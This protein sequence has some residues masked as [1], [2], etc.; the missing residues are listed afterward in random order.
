[1]ALHADLGDDA[2]LLVRVRAACRMLDVGETRLYE[3]LN[4]GELQSF[5]DGGARKI[6]VS[7]IREYIARQMAQAIPPKQSPA[8]RARP[9][10]LNATSAVE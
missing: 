9:E 10:R 3:M 5:R 8:S 7:S 6:L 4:S 1:M 2:P